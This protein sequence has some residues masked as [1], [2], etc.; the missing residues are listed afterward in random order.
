MWGGDGGKVSLLK[1]GLKLVQESALSV[2]KLGHI[3]FG[4]GA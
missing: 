4:L 3:F 2:V 1:L